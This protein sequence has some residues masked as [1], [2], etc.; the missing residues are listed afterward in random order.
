MS[1]RSQPRRRRVATAAAADNDAA[2]SDD[3]AGTGALGLAALLPAPMRGRPAAEDRAQGRPPLELESPAELDNLMSTDDN[4]VVYFYKPECPYCKQFAPAYADLAADVHRTNRGSP[5]ASVLGA[6]PVPIVMAKIDG[7]RHREGINAL[8]DGF[9]GPKY[10]RG[11]PTVLFK[12]GADKVAVTWDSTKPREREAIAAL[13][14]KF[15]GDPTLA[16][17]D[18]ARL[19]DTMRNPDPEFVYFGSDN[20]ELVPRFVR[21]LDPS[22]VD[23]EDALATLALLFTIDA[24]LAARGAFYPANRADRKDIAIPSIVVI[25]DRG[26]TSNGGGD[27][28]MTTYANRD[29]HRWAAAALADQLGIAPPTPNSVVGPTAAEQGGSIEVPQQQLPPRRARAR[30]ARDDVVGSRRLVALA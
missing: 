8:R 3:A 17:M 24:P 10:G 25:N 28:D 11:Y 29:A 2:N 5:A 27:G 9:L 13:M 30:A 15:Y 20:I 21:A 19:A 12:R 18:P 14:A 26:A 6:A 4:A 22:Y 7:A 16:P 23:V 1:L